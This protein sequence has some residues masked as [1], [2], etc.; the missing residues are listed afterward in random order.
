MTGETLPTQNQGDEARR[1][2]LLDVITRTIVLA[3]DGYE[4][5]VQDV[6]AGQQ[7]LPDV[8]LAKWMNEQRI[9][10]QSTDLR[11][12]WEVAVS[13]FVYD[14]L[15]KS[16]LRN[17]DDTNSSEV[18][19]IPMH[20]EDNDWDNDKFWVE[21]SQHQVGLTMQLPVFIF[22]KNLTMDNT[23]GEQANMP[24]A[25]ASIQSTPE[26]V[27]PVIHRIF[28]WYVYGVAERYASG[29]NSD[30]LVNLD[31]ALNTVLE[32]GSKD[33][34]SDT[35]IF[36][37]LDKYVFRHAQNCA[38]QSR[39]RAHGMSKAHDIIVQFASGE[40]RRDAMVR[41]LRSNI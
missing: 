40:R 22:A 14:A 37:A 13:T 23:N 25:Q 5:F 26:K 2:Q 34:V 7:Q 4:K 16:E 12:R 41:S 21:A 17:P 32:Y 9:A 8:D 20:E 31:E 18:P 35:R 30:G 28:D 38:S 3:D 1:N 15:E 39:N 29:Q 33:K 36:R 27:R 10:A 19:T 6:S 24:L 11:T